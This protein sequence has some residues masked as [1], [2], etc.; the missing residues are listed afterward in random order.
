LTSFGPH[1]REK[2]QVIISEKLGANESFSQHF[3]LKITIL[4]NA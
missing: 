1:L 3:L 4:P 2:G